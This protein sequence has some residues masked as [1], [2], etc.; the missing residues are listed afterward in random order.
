ML[1]AREAIAEM[2]PHAGAMCLLE[3][4]LA[5]DADRIRCQSGTHRDPRN[6]L[7]VD[8]D[9]PALCGIEYAAQAMAIHGKLAGNLGHKPKAGYLA[10]L[11]D[12]RCRGG[13][14]DELAGDLIVEAERLMGEESHVMYGFRVWIGEVELLSGRATV[15]LDAGRAKS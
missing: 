13:L 5:W 12:V 15:V 10:S 1:I 3:G 8:G 4:V 11:R 14:L 9:L 6:P 2:I 7:R